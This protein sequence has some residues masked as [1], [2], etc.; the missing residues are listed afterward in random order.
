MTDVSR[1][2]LEQQEAV[3]RLNE[4]VEALKKK[5]EPTGALA[6]AL[7]GQANL[8]RYLEQNEALRRITDPLRAINEQHDLI[9]ASLGRL[10]QG[11]QEQLE[12]HRKMAEG[13]FAEMERTLSAAKAYQGAFRLPQAVEI[14]RLARELV[15]FDAFSSRTLGVGAPL[16]ALTAMEGMRNP[17]L[18][19]ERKV[20]SVRA[21]GD[22]VAI[23]RG[24]ADFAPFEAEWTG[25]LR[26]ILGDW[27]DPISLTEAWS[28]RPARLSLYRERGLDP[29][30]TN[31]PPEAFD[32]AVELVG[33]R[34]SPVV[35]PDEPAEDQGT[36]RS[37]RAF[38]ALLK[39]ERA[40]RRFIADAMEAEFGADWMKHQIP[41]EMLEEWRSKQ[42]KA[43]EAGQPE[44][45]L[46]EYADFTQ[47]K[48]IIERRDNWARVFKAV[49]RRQDDIRESFQR[50][51][52][53]RIATMHA[54]PIEHDDELL[55]M[56][57]TRRLLKAISN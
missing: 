51:F 54:R 2:L 22:L 50:M 38:E 36:A 1:R 17:W 16:A 23:G 26:S 4:P 5:L 55:L 48:T 46:I 37:V 27:R 7:A 34:V 21:F 31:F 19:I 8:E 52:P 57:E 47:Y 9:A 10:P 40:L 18:D 28:D 11:L 44:C 30:L 56:V 42:V 12:A 3:R 49:F 53:L 15:T 6:K 41:G 45:S 33:L 43:M 39:L 32:E 13:P 35:S 24:L 25:G 20:Q 14:G 29:E